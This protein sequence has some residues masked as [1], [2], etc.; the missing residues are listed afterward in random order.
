[1]AS[2]P[3]SMLIQLERDVRAA[4]EGASVDGPLAYYVRE[5]CA[6]DAPTDRGDLDKLRADVSDNR[7]GPM[8]H[9]AQWAGLPEHAHIPLKP[10]RTHWCKRC[11][12]DANTWALPRVRA[13]LGHT[14]GK[15]PAACGATGPSED[16]PCER[17]ADTCKDRGAHWCDG[18]SWP[19]SLEKWLGPQEDAPVKVI[20]AEWRLLARAIEAPDGKIRLRLD[21][22]R[23]H[24]LPLAAANLGTIR[25]TERRQ[26][27]VINDAGRARFAL[28][29]VAKA[30]S[31]RSR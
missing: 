11:E 23:L 21:M 1:M 19:V 25:G 6:P 9:A 22:D 18:S 20:A 5:A 15:L 27:F 16:M 10:Q 30:P 8:T 14:C 24:A 7:A 2:L 17:V 26:H 13:G 31:K 4:L 28:G 29:R 3:P 12:A